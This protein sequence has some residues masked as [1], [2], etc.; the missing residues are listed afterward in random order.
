MMMIKVD[1]VTKQVLTALLEGGVTYWVRWAS[2]DGCEGRLAVGACIYVGPPEG[3][4]DPE[5]CNYNPDAEVDNGTCIYPGDPDCTG[6]DLIVVEDAI[7]NS[8]YATVMEVMN[9]I[10]TL[11]RDV[12]MVMV[13]ERL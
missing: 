6:P 5:A 4:T 3:C 8:I 9:Q 12:S 10:V 11:Q 1:V 2:F 13:I 7:V